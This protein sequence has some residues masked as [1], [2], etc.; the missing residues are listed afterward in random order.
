MERIKELTDRL[1]SEG[2][3]VWAVP[4]EPGRGPVSQAAKDDLYVHIELNP[5]TRRWE[6]VA[7]D[8]ETYAYFNHPRWTDQIYIWDWSSEDDSWMIS[9]CTLIP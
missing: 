7:Y 5:F 8:N 3:A 4:D 6:L 1:E 2:F 9:R